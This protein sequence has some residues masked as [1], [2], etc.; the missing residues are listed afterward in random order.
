MIVLGC[1]IFPVP[2]WWYDEFFFGVGPTFILF[3]A[4][5]PDWLGFQRRRLRSSRRHVKRITWWT[6]GGIEGGRRL[7]QRRTLRLALPLLN[8]LLVRRAAVAERRRFVGGR[9]VAPQSVQLSRY[10]E[11][12]QSSRHHSYRLQLRQRQAVQMVGQVAAEEPVGRLRQ[13]VVQSSELGQQRV[14]RVGDVLDEEG[15]LGED[16]PR[17]TGCG[18]VVVRHWRIVEQSVN[19]LDYFVRV[20]HDVIAVAKHRKSTCCLRKR[21][22][23]SK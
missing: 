19:V 4:S 15:E 11:S 2:D 6:V 23:Y 9:Q 13:V 20:G 18:R 22:A 17:R 8:D 7:G 12:L 1:K 14:R 10:L 3:R 5:S 21:N 16:V